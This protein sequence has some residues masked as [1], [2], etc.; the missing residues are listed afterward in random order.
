MT[1]TLKCLGIKYHV[2]TTLSNDFGKKKRGEQFRHVN[3]TQGEEASRAQCC[4]LATEIRGGDT[5]VSTLLFSKL[6]WSFGIFQ[7]SKLGEVKIK[8]NKSDRE[9]EL[10]LGTSLWPS[11]CPVKIAP[12][13]AAS[14]WHEESL[15][16]RFYQ[17]R[18]T[19]RQVWRAIVSLPSGRRV[20]KRGREW[21]NAKRKGGM[22]EG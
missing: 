6:F 19:S 2:C 7:N 10:W 11:A 17:P 9:Q 20:R 15:I 3:N 1:Y 8:Q 16:V 5:W 12:I 22:K 13:T 14:V 4:Q 18:D 21:R